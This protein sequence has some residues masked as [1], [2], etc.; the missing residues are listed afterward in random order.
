MPL[1]T[2][3]LARA[4]LTELALMQGKALNYNSRQTSW[5]VNRQSTRAVF[6]KHNF[7]FKWTFVEFPGPER[8]APVVPRPARGCV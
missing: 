8:T 5:N 7:A 1:W 4:V 2:R 3:D 6:E